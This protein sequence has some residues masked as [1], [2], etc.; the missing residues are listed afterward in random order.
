MNYL[1]EIKKRIE[2]SSKCFCF[3]LS[4]IEL[5]NHN[6]LINPCLSKSNLEKIESDYDIKLPYDYCEY[7]LNI[8]NGGNQPGNGMLMLQQ[9]LLLMFGQDIDNCKLD[10][11]DLTEYYHSI[12][13]CDCDNLLECYYETFGK[14]SRH[15]H[16]NFTDLQNELDD[17]FSDN[18]VFKY[19]HLLL[20]NNADFM[21]FESEMKLHMLVFSFDCETR[22]QYAIALDGK[23]KHQVIYYSYEPVS[24]LMFGRNIVYTQKSFLE[25]MYNLYD[26]SFSPYDIV[27]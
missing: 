21:R 15:Y 25:W 24:R 8:G 7:L 2:K 13:L 12:N 11:K 3:G 19:Q 1:Y 14:Y 6:L 26:C 5:L 4:N 27:I 17:Y 22:T 18:G 16:P 10:Y 20:N 23:H 9:S